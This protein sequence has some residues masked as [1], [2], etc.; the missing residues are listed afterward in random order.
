MLK[1]NVLLNLCLYLYIKTAL[2]HRLSIDIVDAQ[3]N[4]NSSSVLL[5]SY[6]PKDLQS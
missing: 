3:I 4:N 1:R 2:Q 6:M 5:F